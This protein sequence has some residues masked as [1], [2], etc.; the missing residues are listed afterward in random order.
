VS[1]QE[2]QERTEIDLRIV[3]LDDD[4]E[5]GGS[6]LRYVIYEGVVL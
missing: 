5:S 2:V 1:S 4:D 6:Y 3:R